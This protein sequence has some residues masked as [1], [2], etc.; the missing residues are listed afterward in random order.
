MKIFTIGFSKKSA[1]KF[2][3][4]LI[5]NSVNKVLDIRLNNKSQLAGFAKGRDLEYFLK[6][7]GN[8]EYEYVPGLAPT[9]RLFD[10]YRS[11]KIEWDEFEFMFKKVL[12]ER[13][14]VKRLDLQNL[15]GVCFLCS[16]DL[17]AH[18]HR[19]IVPEEIRKTI[20]C[21]IMHL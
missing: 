10:D 9:K 18:C 14:A 15:D 19:S 1:E 11:K 20:G 16:E 8:I 17:P 13:N 3:G 7:I 6:K 2:F 12:E 4:L 5:S 21:E